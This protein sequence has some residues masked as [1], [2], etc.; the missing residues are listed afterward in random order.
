MTVNTRRVVGVDV[1]CHGGS[2]PH[3][4]DMDKFWHEE[5][6]T[7]YV[8]PGRDTETPAVVPSR[9]VGGGVTSNTIVEVD[10]LLRRFL[11]GFAKIGFQNQCPAVIGRA[12]HRE[13]SKSLKQTGY[14][15]LEKKKEKTKKNRSSRQEICLSY[16]KDF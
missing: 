6:A 11:V 14:L 9:R 3:V 10:F 16:L 7:G 8:A 1:A 4:E 12:G 5:C 13:V 2:S 15:C